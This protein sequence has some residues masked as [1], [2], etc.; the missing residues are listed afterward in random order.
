MQASTLKFMGLAISFLV[1][2]AP[3]H[4]KMTWQEM[5]DLNSYNEFAHLILEWTNV[6][7]ARPNYVVLTP[8]ELES[9]AVLKLHLA[10]E[11]QLQENSEPLVKPI[12]GLAS[13]EYYVDDGAGRAVTPTPQDVWAK[14]KIPRFKHFPPE[15]PGSTVDD[16]C[17]NGAACTTDAQFWRDHARRRLRG[18]YV[19]MP[20]DGDF[21][22]Q[23]NSIVDCSVP[24]CPEVGSVQDFCISPNCPDNT[25]G[26]YRRPEQE[27]E[28]P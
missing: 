4:A 3:V 18:P 10:V 28:D 16:Y 21:R 20:G 25:A 27:D 19:L 1:F 7:D 12:R 24:G 17:A 23:G 5:Q 11:T 14:Q 22:I 2:A 8:T 15:N 26:I 13:E 6:L 9:L